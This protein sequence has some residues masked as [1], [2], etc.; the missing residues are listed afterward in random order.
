M[1]VRVYVIS[2]KFFF[3]LLKMEGAMG[4]EV[5]AVLV[6]QLNLKLRSPALKL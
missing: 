2:Q 1:G 4:Y 3:F 6:Q 5:T